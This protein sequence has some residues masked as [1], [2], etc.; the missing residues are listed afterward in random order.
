ML[1]DERFDY[2][3][4]KKTVDMQFKSDAESVSDMPVVICT[5]GALINYLK[6]TQMTGLE[7]IS[8]IEVY[9][10][11]QYMRLDY[12]TQRNLELTQT[13]LSKE[14]RGSLLWVI[15][16]T[17][18]AMGKRLIRSWL[19]HPLMNISTINNRQSAVEELVNDNMLRL[20]ILLPDA[21][22]LI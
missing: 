6:E 12:N 22:R 9:S 5:I 2:S 21:A 4:C 13:M 10:E 19:E 20:Q 17:K 18:T 14:K 3:L 7:R 1:E 15:D 8:H 16:K 11:S